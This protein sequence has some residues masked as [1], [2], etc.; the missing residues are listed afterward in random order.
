[1]SSVKKGEKNMKVKLLPGTGVE[2][3]HVVVS[4]GVVYRAS[5]DSDYNFVSGNLAVLSPYQM[6]KTLTEDRE[7]FEEAGIEPSTEYFDEY[8]EITID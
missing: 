3:A 5:K 7:A 4:G 2:L 8:Y 1:M 6:C